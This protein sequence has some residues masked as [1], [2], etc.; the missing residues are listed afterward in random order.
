MKFLL[1]LLLAGFSFTVNAQTKANDIIG[2][3][4]DSDG[5]SRFEI[6]STGNSYN[7]KI[8]WLENPKNV[9]GGEMMDKNNPEKS[10]RNRKILGLIIM[11]GLIF[12]VEY[13]T[14]VDGKIY[15]PIRGLTANCK[16]SLVSKN[17]L[18]IKASKYMITNEKR[19][20]RYE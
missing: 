2:K 15:S 10:L 13:N 3:W 1:I 5:K 11:T 12:S 6:F 19:W 8:I 7:A 4:V 17:E 14:W 18:V 16:L 20:K 9:N